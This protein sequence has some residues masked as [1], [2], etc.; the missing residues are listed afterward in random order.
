MSG[1]LYTGLKALHV[2][3]AFTFFAGVLGA[4]VFLA[5]ADAGPGGALRTMGRW[6]QRVTTPA[7]LLVWVLGL[8]LALSGGCFKA[9]WLIAK[10]GF[11]VALSGLHGLQSAK[12]RRLAGGG[13]APAPPRFAAPLAVGVILVIALLAVLKP[14]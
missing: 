5:G 7:M 9:P 4:A 3:A 10:L 8:T 1:D 6:D 2:A 12:L 11:V 14:G 13:P